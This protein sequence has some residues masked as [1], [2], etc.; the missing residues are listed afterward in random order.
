[1]FWFVGN[2]IGLLWNLDHKKERFS[3]LKHVA[4]SFI[5]RKTCFVM[6]DVKLCCFQCSYARERFSS[7]LQRVTLRFAWFYSKKRFYLILDKLHCFRIL[8]LR[9][10]FSFVIVTKLHFWCFILPKQCSGLLTTKLGWFEPRVTKNSVFP[11][12]CLKYPAFSLNTG[13]T[14][15]GLFAVKL[16]CY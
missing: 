12:L 4:L 15:F 16:G 9:T 3:C 1:M 2:E 6:F 14:S 13:K 5:A 7:S 11:F 10:I 8:F